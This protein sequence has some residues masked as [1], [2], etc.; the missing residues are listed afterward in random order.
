MCGNTIVQE[1]SSPDKNLRAVIFVRD[2][3][4][5]TG[6]SAQLSI[7]E[8]SENLEN[9]SGNVLITD[10]NERKAPVAEHGGVV[11]I[12]EWKSTKELVVYLDERAQTFKKEGR[13]KG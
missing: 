4:A 12:V 11:I 1:V 10:D 2:C 6:F 3:G 13:I 9:E 5:T 8:Q 7:L